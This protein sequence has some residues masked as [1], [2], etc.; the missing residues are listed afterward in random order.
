MVGKDRVLAV[1][2]CGRMGTAVVHGLHRSPQKVFEHHLLYDADAEQAKKLAQLG[3]GE[4]ARTMLDAVEKADVLLLA[5]KPQVMREV[6][7]ELS[8]LLSEP[9]LLMSV[10]AGVS[11]SYLESCLGDKVRVVRAMP[12]TP[13]LVGEGVTALCRGSRAESSDEEMARQIFS[14]LGAVYSVA[15][16]QMDAITALSGSG[17]AYF[18]L[19]AEALIDAGVDLGLTRKLATDLVKGTLAGTAALWK[20]TNEHPVLLKEQVTSPGGTTIA[21]LRKLEEGGLRKAVF[22]A[23]EGAFLR[24]R[25]LSQNLAKDGVL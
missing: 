14:T 3:G 24:S 4:A 15:E 19:L 9:K 11:T 18:L 20:E 22:A 1:I 6:V 5:V 16:E 10:A 7:G 12:N 21:A 8:P 25:E 17:P 2:G 23:A 13:C